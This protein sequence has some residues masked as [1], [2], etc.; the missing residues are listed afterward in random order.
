MILWTVYNNSNNQDIDMRSLLL[1]TIMFSVRT[2]EQQSF[3]NRL[4]K[5]KMN[6][7]EEVL[8]HVRYLYQNRVS[9][10]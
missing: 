2:S 4:P 8:D 3:I 10:G 7:D 6:R 1:R 5:L 9:E